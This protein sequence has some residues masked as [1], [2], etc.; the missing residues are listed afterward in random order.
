[1]LT[2]WLIWLDYLEENNC[3]TTFLRFVTPVVFGIRKSHNYDRLRERFHYGS[4][5]GEGA[6][7]FGSGVGDGSYYGNNWGNNIY[8][9]GSCLNHTFNFDESD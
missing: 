2:D 9:F 4:G 3:N 6:N 5:W 7:S 1:M 8:G